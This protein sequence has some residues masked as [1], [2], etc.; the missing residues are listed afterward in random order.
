M[1]VC[2]CVGGQMLS[3]TDLVR[4]TLKLLYPAQL[5]VVGISLVYL[6]HPV[7]SVAIA[8]SDQNITPY[9]YLLHHV[10]Y[11]LHYVVYTLHHNL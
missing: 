10:V 5:F 2:T 6:L 4:K 3:Q 7:A 8:L 11:T 9:S 1:H